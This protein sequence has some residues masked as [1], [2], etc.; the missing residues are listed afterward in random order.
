MTLIFDT[1]DRD[2]SVKLRASFGN[3][4]PSISI[5]A[6][7]GVTGVVEDEDVDD[8]TWSIVIRFEGMGLSVFDF[9]IKE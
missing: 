3:S 1:A 5:T 9:L 4:A 6:V 2:L 7:S 8:D